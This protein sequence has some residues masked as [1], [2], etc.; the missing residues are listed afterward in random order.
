[1]GY[2]D[3]YNDFLDL[4]FY[5]I[6][7]KWG[8]AISKIKDSNGEIKVRLMKCKKLDDFPETEMFEWEELDPSERENLNISGGRIN[9]KNE[10]ELMACFSELIEVFK[11]I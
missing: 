3:G 6:G 1:M 11:T 9:F 10:E 8:W 5:W 4:K 2:Y 7:W